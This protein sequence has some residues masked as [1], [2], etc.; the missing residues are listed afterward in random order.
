MFQHADQ[1]WKATHE[2]QQKDRSVY[3]VGNDD[4]GDNNKRFVLS[5]RVWMQLA[6]RDSVK[7]ETQRPVCPRSQQRSCRP[8][9]LIGRGFSGSERRRCEVCSPP[10]VQE[11]EPEPFPH[12]PIPP[13]RRSAAKPGLLKTQRRSP[14]TAGAERW[15]TVHCALH[16]AKCVKQ[17]ALWLF[18][19]VYCNTIL[20]IADS[21]YYACNF[22]YE[23][24][25][26][27][28]SISVL[29]TILF[30]KYVKHYLV[31]LW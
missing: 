14:L 6:L 8:E 23:L 13:A 4:D 10:W 22:L 5:Y 16:C 15:R 2:M 11:W 25:T 19:I 18:G 17:Y 24:D 1:I 21:V 26:Q 20:T 31:W 28:T 7:A 12:Q 27:V 30:E 29:P 3:I 9:L